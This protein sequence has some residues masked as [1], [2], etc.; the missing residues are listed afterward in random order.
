MAHRSKTRHLQLLVSE[1]E[2]N[3]IK[4]K[5]QQIGTDN[6]S[7]YARKMLID[8]YVIKLQFDEMKSLT[9]ELANLSRSINQIAKRVNSTGNLYEEDVKDVKRMYGEAKRKIEGCLVKLIRS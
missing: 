4:Q 5:M 6:F 9:K 7:L 3:M 1:E 2:L 8:G